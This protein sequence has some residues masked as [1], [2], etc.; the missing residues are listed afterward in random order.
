MP[1]GLAPLGFYRI[2]KV[3]PDCRHTSSCA[4]QTRKC[5]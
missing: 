4:E 3:V 1:A 2:A 5:W